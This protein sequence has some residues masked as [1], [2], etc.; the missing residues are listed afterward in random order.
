MKPPSYSVVAGGRYEATWPERSQLLEGD[1]TMTKTELDE[2]RLAR[3]LGRVMRLQPPPVDLSP[4]H[5]ARWVG[6]LAIGLL[7][8][9]SIASVITVSLVL[10]KHVGA[11][12]QQTAGASTTPTAIAATN[13]SPS[14]PSWMATCLGAGGIGTAARPGE[15]TLTSDQ[16]VATARGYSAALTSA[17]AAPF[18]LHFVAPTAD[19][20]TVEGNALATPLWAVGFSGFDAQ[21]PGGLF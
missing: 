8:A 14:L 21:L 12:A 10:H 20:G 9:A 19:A 3:S 16:A 5:S 4:R 7:T 15:P 2:E 6:S 17:P 1:Y 11:P 18:Y 13:S